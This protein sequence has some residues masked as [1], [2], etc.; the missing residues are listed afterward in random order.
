MGNY[1]KLPPCDGD[2]LNCKRRARNCRGRDTDKH[3][4][5]TKGTRPL[6][7]LGKGDFGAV[8]VITDGGDGR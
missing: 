8:K 5:Y 4:P 7:H 1:R 3:T 2:C 6:D